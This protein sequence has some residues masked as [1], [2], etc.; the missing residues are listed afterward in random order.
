MIDVTTFLSRDPDLDDPY[1]FYHEL[2]HRARVMW[3]DKLGHWL[4]TGYRCALT[5]LRHDH[6]S[7]DRRNWS[8]YRLPPGLERPPGG[9]FAMDRPD[10]TRLR[11]LVQQ[12][13][14]PRLVQR[15]QPETER[16]TDRML[17]DMAE[18]DEIDLMS[19]FA[20]PLPATVLAELLGVPPRDHQLFSAWSATFT[21]AIDPVSHRM[22]SP[23]GTRAH[24]D[25]TGYLTAVIDERRRQPR[26]DLISGL[27][28][29][30]AAGG[31]LTGEELVEMCTLLVVAGFETT[32]NLIGN[33]VHALLAHPDQLARLR[34]RPA[35]V[36]TAVEELLRYDPP[37]QVSGRVPLRDIELD[38]QVLRRGQ[39]VGILLGAVNRDPEA[40]PEPDRLDLTRAPN[41]HLAFGHGIHFCLGAPLARM[42][43]AVALAAL[44]TRFPGLSLAGDPRRRSDLHVRGFTSLPV[45]LGPSGS[46]GRRSP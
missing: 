13:F 14:T 37:I 19:D 43:G 15:L 28:R 32:V 30:E 5:L 34:A 23:E 39:M 38:G 20:G 31:G 21:G 44:V 9:M 25:L 42:V 11:G 4:V 8:A 22:T 17:A 10:H 24:A 12:A 18:R 16:L 45:A 26:P 36:A 27:L 46:G 7:S 1:D 33:G 3:V 40:F 29:A 6:V 2:R 41:H 35:M